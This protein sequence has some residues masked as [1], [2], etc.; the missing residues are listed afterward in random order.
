MWHTEDGLAHPLEER[1]LRLL[2]RELD[3]RLILHRKE[4]RVVP[5]ILQ[6]L[7]YEVDD[8]LHVPRG[9]VGW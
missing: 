4:R 2:L 5:F 9:G 3:V 7:Q 6:V 1:P 8:V